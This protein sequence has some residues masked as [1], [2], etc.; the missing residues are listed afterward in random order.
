MDDESK[1]EVIDLATHELAE[2]EMNCHSFALLRMMGV[3]SDKN[4]QRI[5]NA[6]H[7]NNNTLAPF[8]CLR[9][10]HKPIEPGKEKEGPKTRP[11]CGATDCLT[12]RTSYILSKLLV[13][14]I[15]PSNTQCNSTENL[16]EEIK[17]LNLSDVDIEW[18][19]S[20]LD[21]EALY[22]SLDIK[23]CARVI[24]QKLLESPFNI[25]GLNWVEIALYLRFQLTD[26]EIKE[27]QLDEYCPTRLSKR[28]RPPKFTASGLTQTSTKDWVRGYTIKRYHLMQKRKECSVWQ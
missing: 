22:P 11:L 6:L 12:R 27:N 2:K 26:E 21:V 17:K 28:G 9:K 20:S 13:D 1:T 16:I 5:R 23:E 3:K 25:T 18:I 4:G 7:S 8:Y 24:E 10:D 19:E 15:Q 14:L